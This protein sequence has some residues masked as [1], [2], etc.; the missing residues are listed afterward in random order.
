MSAWVWP[1][2]RGAVTESEKRASLAAVQYAKSQRVAAEEISQMSAQLVQR[3]GFARN[4]HNA[5]KGMQD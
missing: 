2:R 1:W 4:I 5:L 3:N